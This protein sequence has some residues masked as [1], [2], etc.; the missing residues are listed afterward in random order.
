M[1]WLS[2]KKT[3]VF[4]FQPPPMP[5]S[6]PKPLPALPAPASQEVAISD[7]KGTVTQVTTLAVEDKKGES[8]E[9]WFNVTQWTGTVLAAATVAAAGGKK[10]YDLYRSYNSERKE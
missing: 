8:Q 7:E 6:A 5:T 9:V 4:H 2:S 3:T 1:P 10:A